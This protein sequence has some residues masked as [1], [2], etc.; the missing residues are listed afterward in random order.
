MRKK[1]VVIGLDCAAPDLVFN[2]WTKDLPH[3]RRLMAHGVYGRLR[4]TNPPITVPAWASMVTSQDP[5]Q[6]GIY[7]FRNRG[8]Y[9]YANETI[10][11]S[12]SLKAPAIWDILGRRGYKSIVLGVPP[13]FPP[14]P[15]NGCA[16]S[17]FLTPGTHTTYTYPKE[18]AAEVVRV[19]G[20][21]AFDVENFRTSDTSHILKQIY[22]MTEKRFRLASHLVRTK[23]WDF[24]MMVEMGTDRIHHAF[25]HY[26]DEKHVLHVPHSSYR[27]AIY[28]YY[29]FVDGQ[30]GQLLSHFPPDT[31][32]LVVSDHGA[33]RMDGG[34]CLNE[35]LI[36]ER[37]LVLKQPVQTVTPL[38]A[39]MVDWRK[40]RAWGQ[41]GYYGRLNLNV[42]GREPHG[43]IP[44]N[45]YEVVRNTL[46]EK[47]RGLE[48]EN[49]EP[50]PT[51]VFK[52]SKIYRRTR[53]IPP[54]L[55]VYFGDLYWRAIGSV[56]H[57]TL[58]VYKNDIG[59]DGA[60]HDY[61]GIVIGTY[62]K[63][64]QSQSQ[65]RSQRPT[66]TNRNRL[67]QKASIYDIAPT[68]LRQFGI[69]AT[70]AMRGKVLPLLANSV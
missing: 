23:P 35:W 49:G 51:K 27:H 28:D 33:K 56:G 57:H 64:L 31:L 36:R 25:W 43:I 15:L 24:F 9:D 65:Q 54:D 38:T 63:R 21:Y 70:R 68:V 42:K 39:D 69:A 16:V 26:M 11:D 2:E 14:K 40:T 10:V 58:D 61:E 3:L 62:L 45:R 18:L 6:L 30:I 41:G 59:P 5:G 20:D 8:S 46:I 34:F 67:L 66:R 22:A 13:S 48:T 37:L 4:S 32:V 52:P 50:L 47:L 1:V 19:V 12:R 53:N 60:N 17:C 7:G 29:K 44:S 55:L